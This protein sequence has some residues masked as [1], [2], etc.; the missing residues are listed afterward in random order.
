MA[1]AIITAEITSLI[2]QFKALLDAKDDLAEQTKRN[3]T[4]VIEYLDKL[5]QAM[6]DAEIDQVGRHGI[7]WKLKPTTKYSKKAGKD[8]ELFDLLRDHG[9]G[10]LIKETVNA[11]TLQGAMSEFAKENDDELPEEFAEVI[12]V[13]EYMDISHRKATKSTI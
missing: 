2:D 3:N 10:D 1:D 4:E 11:Q 5:A 12:S 7:N 6:V 13:Y 8:A 9:L